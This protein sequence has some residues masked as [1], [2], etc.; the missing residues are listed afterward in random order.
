LSVDLSA[1]DVLLIQ[2]WDNVGV[3]EV[4]VE[5]EGEVGRADPVGEASGGV[6]RY[7]LGERSAAA[8]IF[9]E[10]WMG[11]VGVWEEEGD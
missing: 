9:A 8:R 7:A 2:V 1:D 11:N 4:R 10:D 3:K 6:W 5:I